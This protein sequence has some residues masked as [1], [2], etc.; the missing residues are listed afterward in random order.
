MTKKIA[1][2]VFDN[3]PL[4]ST[5]DQY[6]KWIDMARLAPPGSAGFCEECTPEYQALIVKQ[7]KCLHPEVVFNADGDGQIPTHEQSVIN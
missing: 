2:I 6:R 7:H 3:T 1:R 5:F 4:C